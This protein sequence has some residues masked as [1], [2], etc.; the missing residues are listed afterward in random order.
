MSDVSGKL[1]VCSLKNFANFIG[2]KVARRKSKPSLL[3]GFRNITGIDF[4]Y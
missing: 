1:T 4:R 3:N 2:I